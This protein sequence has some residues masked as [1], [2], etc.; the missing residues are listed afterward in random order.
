[1]RALSLVVLVLAATV[2][3][4]P[5]DTPAQV[6]KAADGHRL[7]GSLDRAKSLYE[8]VTASGN[9]GTAVIGENDLVQGVRALTLFSYSRR[10]LR[11]AGTAGR[12]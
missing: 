3:A 5:A 9:I 2:A 8:S 1:M 10:A 11:W 12:P 4:V 7:A 6:C